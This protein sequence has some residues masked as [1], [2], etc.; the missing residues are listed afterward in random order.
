MA[1]AVRNGADAPAPSALRPVDGGFTF[2]FRPTKRGTAVVTVK[3]KASPLDI[4]S[5]PVKAEP[6]R[7][8]AG[9]RCP[10]TEVCLKRI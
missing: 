9:A 8:V 6:A 3:D 5:D 7:V 2:T 1:P 4:T 10:P